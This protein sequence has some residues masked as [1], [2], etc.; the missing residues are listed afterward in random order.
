MPAEG[1]ACVVKAAEGGRLGDRYRRRKRLA[2]RRKMCQM[3]EEEEECGEGGGGRGWELEEDEVAD[4]TAAGDGAGKLWC[5]EEEIQWDHVSRC[6]HRRKEETRTQHRGRCAA[7]WHPGHWN[8]PWHRVC[9]VRF[10][11]TPHPIVSVESTERAEGR[12]GRRGR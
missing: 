7:S 1:G 10:H 4:A 12:W 11:H 5:S 8:L 2:R 6:R 3:Q 9:P